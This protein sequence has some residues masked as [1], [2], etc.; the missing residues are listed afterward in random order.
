M[1]RLRR[2]SRSHNRKKPGSRN[3]RKAA[4]R[5]ARAHRRV[6]NQRRDFL[7]TTTTVLAKTKPLIVVEDLHVRGMVLNRRLSRRI[8]D[9]GWGEFRRMLAYKTAWYGSRLYVA[10]RFFASS[11]RCSTCGALKE[12]YPLSERIYRCECCGAVLD[13]DLNAARNLLSLVAESCVARRP[14]TPAERRYDPLRWACLRE[15]GTPWRS[16]VF[17]VRP[18]DVPRQITTCV[19]PGGPTKA[20]GC[21]SVSGSLTNIATPCRRGIKA[22]MDVQK[23]ARISV[24]NHSVRKHHHLP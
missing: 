21:R 20:S 13:R 23:A 10:P 14:K 24:W 6:R 5:L 15:A 3:R 9:A 22:T 12:E 8:A 4:R 1:R 18:D 16:T 7:H 11:K 19:H 17:D 2:L